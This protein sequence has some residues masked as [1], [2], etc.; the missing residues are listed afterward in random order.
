MRHADP[1][2]HPGHQRRVG[3]CAQ[4]D[5]HDDCDEYRQQHQQVGQLGAHEVLLL[6]ALIP[7]LAQRLTQ[8]RDPA[9]SGPGRGRQADH[10]HR[11]AGLDRR[12]HQADQLLAEVTGNCC[13][14][15][16]FDI[17]QQ[18]RLAREHEAAGREADHQQREQ[19]ED[20]EVGDA[21]GVEITL[22]VLVA[23]SG[24]DRMVEPVMASPQS[25]QATRFGRF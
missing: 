24:P 10:T 12:I 2:Q 14:D 20:R 19:R 5:R 25:I 18:V 8:I 11:R 6:D 15:P 17:G 23:P 1:L 3:Q 22:D 9:Q 16:V 4:R 7:H 21:R 13:P